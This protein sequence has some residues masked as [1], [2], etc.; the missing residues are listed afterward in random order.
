MKSSL[1]PS[2]DG[3]KN[4]RNVKNGRLSFGINCKTTKEVV[5]LV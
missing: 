3:W 5:E 2:V 4:A 1:E